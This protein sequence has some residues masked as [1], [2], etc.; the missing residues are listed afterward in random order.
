M[1]ELSEA[2]AR[3]QIRELL[4]EMGKEYTWVTGEVELNMRVGEPIQ[5]VLK[6]ADASSVL[7]TTASG[8]R[9]IAFRDVVNLIVTMA[10]PGPE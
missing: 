1:A 9:R 4:A 8:E 5:G 2:E 7:L 10:S 3:R 6:S